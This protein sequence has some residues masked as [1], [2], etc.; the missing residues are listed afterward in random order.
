MFAKMVSA[1]A[2]VAALASPALAGDFTVRSAAPQAAY[3][4][5]QDR[6]YGPGDVVA[7]TVAGA[8]GT[9]A[10]IA[11]AP[12]APRPYVYETDSYAYY[13]GPY[14]TNRDGPYVTS[15]EEYVAPRYVRPM[16]RGTYWN[17]PVGPVCEPGT[18]VRALDGRSYLCQ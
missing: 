12:L 14:V 15:T 13:D 16:A 9:A 4:E 6:I 17:D 3:I 2:V 11:T 8:L 7:G 10:A 5:R 18:L 1:G